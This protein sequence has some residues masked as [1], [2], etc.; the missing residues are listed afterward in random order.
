MYFTTTGSG[1]DGRQTNQFVELAWVGYEFVA[2]T[3]SG[4][5]G[6]L[7]RKSVPPDLSLLPGAGMGTP[8]LWRDHVYDPPVGAAATTGG[9]NNYLLTTNVVLRCEF[10]YYPTL[11]SLPAG[12][13]PRCVR[14]RVETVDLKTVSQFA[15]GAPA[16]LLE[17]NKYVLESQV[18]LWSS[19]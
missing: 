5:P 14:I 10:S 6:Y 11:A 9:A 2:G 17:S 13:L 8:S 12:R 15:A 1:S 4:M 18:Y 19:R 7:L 16:S 3:P